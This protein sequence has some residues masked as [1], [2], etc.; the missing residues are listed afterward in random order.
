VVNF[1]TRKDFEGIDVNVDYGQTDRSDGERTS[2]GVTFGTRTDNA[3]FILG[4]NWNEQKQVLANNR[5][6]SRFALYLYSGSA[7]SGGSSRTPNGRIGIVTGSPLAGIFGC[8]SVTRKAGAAGTSLNDF[9]CYVSTGANSD[10]YNYQPINL[11]MTPQER[12]SAFTLLNYQINDSLEA[13]A[14]VLLS[15]TRSAYQIAPLP[16]DATQDDVIISKDSMYNPFGVDFGGL[17]TGNPNARFRMEALGPRR[18]EYSTDRRIANVGL[19]GELFGSGWQWDAYLS[20][21]RADSNARAD[22]YLY[23]PALSAAFGPS[24]MSAGIPT[25]GTPAAPISGCT[26]VNLFNLTAPGQAD[27]LRT[28]AAPST[29]VGLTT[30]KSAAVDFNGQLFELS[31]GAVQAA[32]GLEYREQFLDFKADFNSQAKAPLFLTCNLAQETCTGD[33]RGGYDVK[34]AYAEVF[35]P[36]LADADFAKALNL[37]VGT[38]FSDYST[39]GSDTNSQVKIE[40]R[41]IDDLLFR[42]SWSQVLR[43]P[44]IGD[45]F[46]ATTNG[47]PQFEDPC[48]GLTNARV[49]ATP[50][51][52]LACVGVLRDGTFDQPNSQITGLYRSNANLDPETGTVKTFGVVFEPSALPGLSVSLDYWDYKIESILQ[53]LDPQYAID[54]CVASGDPA[55]CGL[56]NRFTSGAS[57][58]EIFFFDLPTVNLGSL[59]TKGLDFGVKYTLRDTPVGSFQFSVDVTRV[60]EYVGVASDVAAPV[61]YV[62][63]YTNQYGNLAQYRGL[64]SVGWVWNKVDALLTSR[65]VSSAT[66]PDGDAGPGTVTPLP[67]GTFFYHDLTVGYELP[68][69]TRIQVGVQNLADKQPPIL[70]QNNVLN[71][72]TDV[73]TYDTLGRRFFM[74]INHKF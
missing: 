63:T 15:R 8:G 34:E 11:I 71:A 53:S 61:E 69:N 14:E 41:P 10:A 56:I 28:I 50:N 38:R 26:P 70:Y 57:Q 9:R 46:G 40:Y 42:G 1:I 62:G 37:T 44:T 60:N 32:V 49:T 39:F 2:V 7:Y 20:Y 66:I 47:S 33:T 64:A 68:T 24:F 12:G 51:L 45:L 31:A 55:F 6:F 18:T 25:C 54:E 3:S 52:A 65:Y 21:A 59:S 5:D 23:Q 13:Y 43:A 16:F 27:A 4:A 29:S 22:G 67:T 17:T 19:K 72:N 74:S 58:G 36:L 73:G 30:R 48:N 35:F